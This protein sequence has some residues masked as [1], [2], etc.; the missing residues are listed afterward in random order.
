MCRIGVEPQEAQTGA[1]QCAAEHDQ[2]ARARYIGNQQ[3]FGEFHVTRQVA[4]DAQGAADHHRRHDC[5]AVE[6]VGKVDRVARA[7][8][9]EVSQHDEADAQRNGDILDER[10]DQRGFDAGRRGLVQEDRSR[11]AEHRLPEIL[12]AARQTAGV[13]LDHLA[14][15]VDPADRAEQQGHR[16][17]HPHVAVG[18]IGPQQGADGDGGQDQRA[19]H[20]RRALLR[21]V[22]LRTVVAH[23]LADKHLHSPEVIPKRRHVEER[24][25]AGY[26]CYILVTDLA[27][28]V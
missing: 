15:V 4:E 6:A 11:Q 7:D 25:L 18:E 16:Q 8:D 26:F 9:D 27:D 28:M 13:L 17:H 14:V 23:R 5:Q 19:T 10:Q 21:Q 2:F 22:R 24:Y 12:P 20:G 3:V 1:N